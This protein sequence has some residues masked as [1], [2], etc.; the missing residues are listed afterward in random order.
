MKNRQCFW[1]IDTKDGV[2]V[3]K[4]KEGE[5]G[6]TVCNVD[7]RHDLKFI[8]HCLYHSNQRRFGLMPFEVDQIVDFAFN[9]KPY[10]E[11]YPTKIETPKGRKESNM[12]NTAVFL[13]NELEKKNIFR[14]FR[15]GQ[16]KDG[17]S[18]YEKKGGKYINLGVK[19]KEAVYELK[20]WKIPT[21][22]KKD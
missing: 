17:H 10:E 1:A 9:D 6:H 3:I 15:C 20:G 13:R 4:L 5:K 18:Y 12:A 22:P 7:K 14:G 21:A 2:A 11:V 16:K 8:R 19:S